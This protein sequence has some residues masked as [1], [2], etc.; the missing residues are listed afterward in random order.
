VLLI[1]MLNAVSSHGHVNFVKH[2][3]AYSSHTV[4]Q[5]SNMAVKWHE[6]S[7]LLGEACDVV[8]GLYKSSDSRSECLTV[9]LNKHA[10]GRESCTASVA[11]SS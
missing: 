7:N 2:T 11:R 3:T 5:S 9:V 10:H 6:S 4:I 8:D 1:L